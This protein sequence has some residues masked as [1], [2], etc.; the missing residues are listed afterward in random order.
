M[1][2]VVTASGTV[3]EYQFASYPRKSASYNPSGKILIRC[4]DEDLLSNVI[5]E[6]KAVPE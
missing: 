4:G 2:V 1:G 5:E 3:D 6:N